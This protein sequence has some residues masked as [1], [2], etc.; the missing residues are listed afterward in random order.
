MKVLITGHRGF[1]GTRFCAL[2]KKNKI[3]HDGFDLLEGFDIRNNLQLDK[4]FEAGQYDVVI[5]L[6]ALAGVRRGQEF[7][8]EYISTNITG[9]QNIIAMCEKYNIGRLIFFSSSSVLGGIET[10]VGL[11]ETDS[12]NP[13]SLYAI[14]KLTGEYL[15]ST[16]NINKTIVRPFTVYG[17]NGRPDMVVYKW[18]NQ[19]KSGKPVTV[20]GDGK[21]VRGYTY[22]GDLVEVIYK[23]LNKPYNGIL[24]LGGSERIQ[25]AKLFELFHEHCRKKKIK[26]DVNVSKIPKEDVLSSFANC[27]LARNHIGFEPQKRFETIIKKI[28]RKEL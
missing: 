19:I 12:Y 21:S 1:I 6:A 10:G 27:I 16:A 15:V 2:L 4:Q 25:L 13:K 17:E 26:I 11:D 5:H 8:D 23:L 3:A 18:I 22:V 14:T 24:H 7:P 9:T 20:F 28:L